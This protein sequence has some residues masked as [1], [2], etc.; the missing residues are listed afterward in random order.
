MFNKCLLK[1]SWY[2]M[3]KNSPTAQKD[4]HARIAWRLKISLGKKPVSDGI[5][6]EAKVRQQS[7]PVLPWQADLAPL[8]GHTCTSSPLFIFRVFFP[9][10]QWRL[11]CITPGSL[12]PLGLVCLLLLCPSKQ[13]QHL[14]GLARITQPWPGSGNTKGD[15]HAHY[16]SPTAH[17]GRQITCGLASS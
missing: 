2:F 7:K 14:C 3:K 1:S 12:P 11:R 10:G 6:D 9:S 4:L 15:T 17:F 16:H 5:S 13:L 8:F